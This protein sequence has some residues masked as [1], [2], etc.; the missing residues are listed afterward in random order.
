MTV[1]I[2]DVTYTAYDILI[3]DLESHGNKPGDAHGAALMELVG[4]MTEYAY[5]KAYGRKAFGLPTG[6]GKTS[7]IISWI[8]A[9][10]RLGLEDIAVS[11]AASQVE[12]LCGIKR[13]LIEHGVPE[14]QI[15]L[16]HSQ[17]GI[18]SEPSTGREDRRFQ[19]VTHARVRAGNDDE[20]FL[21]HKGSRRKVMIYDETL[22]RSDT[23]SVPMHEVSVA[24]AAFCVHAGSL[25]TAYE[26]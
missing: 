23:A 18:A 19:L 7:A 26:A 4:T 6:C 12:A 16:K 24:L 15:G 5:G 3:K 17:D 10:H 8:T 21:K 13:K 20:L 22:F 25:G 9:I 11:V 1:S 14:H 2:F